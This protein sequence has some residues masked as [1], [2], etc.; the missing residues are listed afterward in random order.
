MI[1]GV[2]TG[3]YPRLYATSGLRMLHISEDRLESVQCA[4]HKGP[5]RVRIPQLPA[6]PSYQKQLPN[7]TQLQ[8]SDSR[9]YH[10]FPGYTTA[11]RIKQA[12]RPELVLPPAGQSSAYFRYFVQ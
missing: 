3:F 5:K 12:A 2:L 4:R 10:G 11:R 9:D 8:P 1:C 6:A 7:A